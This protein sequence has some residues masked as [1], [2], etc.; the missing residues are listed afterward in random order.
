MYH[1]SH[2]VP[3]RLSNF[4]YRVNCLSGIFCWC[5]N[6]NDLHLYLNFSFFNFSF[7]GGTMLT[8]HICIIMYTIILSQP[9]YTLCKHGKM[10]ISQAASRE[11]N[12]WRYESIF[13]VNSN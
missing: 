2:R 7:V 11:Q 8:R 9:K 12:V 5:D 3:G 4:I 1:I 13:I 10:C 6:K